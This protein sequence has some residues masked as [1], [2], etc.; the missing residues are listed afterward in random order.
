M[1]G[2]GFGESPLDYLTKHYDLINKY[3][4]EPVLLRR[5]KKNKKKHGLDGSNRHQI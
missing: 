3:Y 5:E 1:S 4:G 2:T